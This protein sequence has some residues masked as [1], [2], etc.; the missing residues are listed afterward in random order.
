MEITSH[1]DEVHGA[2]P[3]WPTRPPP[4]ARRIGGVGESQNNAWLAAA[5]P[6]RGVPAAPRPYLIAAALLAG[7]TVWL[8]GG[9]V[10]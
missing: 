10:R 6:A 4:G 1:V 7:L 9:A 5:T 8:A 2:N 3:N